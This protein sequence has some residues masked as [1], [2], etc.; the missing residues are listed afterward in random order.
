MQLYMTDITCGDKF[1]MNCT[2]WNKG[3]CS[4]FNAFR[5]GNTVTL[6]DYFNGKLESVDWSKAYPVGYRP[7][8]FSKK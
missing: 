1:C 7:S 3:K 6:C 2:Y 8:T 4:K 5:I